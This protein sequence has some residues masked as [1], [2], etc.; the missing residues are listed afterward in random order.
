MFSRILY[1]LS[2]GYFGFVIYKNYNFLGNIPTEIHKANLLLI[3]IALIL[4][5]GKYFLLAYNFH[6]NFEKVGIKFK[7]LDKL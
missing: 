2:A 3:L 7:F 5:V 1:V 4:Q 6:L